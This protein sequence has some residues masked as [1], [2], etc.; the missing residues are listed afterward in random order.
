MLEK[1]PESYLGC[2]EIQQVH[3]KGDQSWVFIGRSDVEAKT[4][5]FWPPDAKSWLIWKDPDAGKDWRRRRR[6][7]QR[8]RW[9]DGITG[10]VDMSFSKLW[11]DFCY[12][13]LLIW[14]DDL[15]STTDDIFISFSHPYLYFLKTYSILIQY[16]MLNYSVYESISC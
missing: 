12:F 13:Y 9:L 4:L 1:T 2:K 6:G 11:V 10:S 8:M 5:K 3:H 7:Q 16:V 15:F 14:Y